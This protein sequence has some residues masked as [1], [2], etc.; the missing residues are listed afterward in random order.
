MAISLKSQNKPLLAMILI[1]NVAVWYVLAIVGRSDISVMSDLAKNW[2][3]LFPAGLG[4]IV[5]GI[6]IEQFG[7]VMKA[8][9]VFWRWRHPLPGS[10]AFTK[11]G[12]ADPRVDMSAI[13]AKLGILP[14]EP[15]EQNR[16]WYQKLYKPL[17]ADAAVAGVHKEYLFLRDYT[18]LAVVFLVLPGLGLWL[19][20]SPRAASIY[21]LC[22]VAQY[23]LVRRAA[24]SAG[25]RMV[26]NV[27]ALAQ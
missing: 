26:T 24:S 7:A 3:S 11:L 8:R 20:M 18:C 19:G 16:V 22:L 27:L 13:S 14:T 5:V 10:Q 25:K 4:V 6:L 21:E 17:Q 15:G 9:L 12:P 23:F 1:V 2:Q